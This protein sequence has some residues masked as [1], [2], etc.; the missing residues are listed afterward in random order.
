M[1]IS[2][3]TMK[4]GNKKISN[5]SGAA[6]ESEQS[7]ELRV[8]SNFPRSSD[9]KRQHHTPIGAQDGFLCGVLRAENG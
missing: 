8:S 1:L 9:S 3:R 6:E 5:R 7:K 4:I 2:I